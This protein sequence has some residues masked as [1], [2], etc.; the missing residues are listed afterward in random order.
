MALH[1]ASLFAGFSVC[2]IITL[3]SVGGFCY[4]CLGYCV[5][6]LMVC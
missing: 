1:A 4:V 2:L 3:I 6:C 5:G